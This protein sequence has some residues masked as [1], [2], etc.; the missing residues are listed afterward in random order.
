MVRRYAVKTKA[1][2]AY[3]AFFLTFLGI[4]LANLNGKVT[5]FDDLSIY[6]WIFNFGAALVTAGT[7]WGITNPVAKQKGL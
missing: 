6:E 7:V 1:Y 5:N 2:K 4:L 3:G